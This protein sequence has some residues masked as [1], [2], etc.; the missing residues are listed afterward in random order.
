MRTIFTL[1]ATVILFGNYAKAQETMYMYKLGYIADS[2]VI[3]NIDSILFN[4]AP[5]KAMIA[6]YDGNLYRTVTIGTQEWFIENL[7]TTHFN[8]G[9]EIPNVTA[10]AAWS[11]LDSPA[12]CWYN[13]DETLAGT[14]IGILYNWYTVET[15]K[16]CPTGWHTATFD[17]WETLNNFLGGSD[18]SGGKMK[19]IGGG[20]LWYENY[21][22]GN[23]GASNSSNFNGLASG[24]RAI[25]GTFADMGWATRFWT[26]TED[27]GDPTKAKFKMLH[28]VTANLWQGTEKK[29]AGYA[30]R[31]IKD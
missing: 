17:E 18:V 15:Y 5:G 9:V 14:P 26:E 4:R 31:C 13:N 7:K 30:V 24:V 6:D 2:A 3:S 27:S 1:I 16:L 12:Y 28:G 20:A 21:E 10:N 29:T 19:T 23:L 22:G 11:A 25:D 8:D